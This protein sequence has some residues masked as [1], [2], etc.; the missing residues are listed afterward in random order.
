M[1]VN[2]HAFNQQV[3]DNILDLICLCAMNGKSE[4][5]VFLMKNPSFLSFIY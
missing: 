1:E 3:A 4:M 5:E 2:N